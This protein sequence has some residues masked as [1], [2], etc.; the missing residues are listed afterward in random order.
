M[1]GDYEDI[2][3]RS[4][5]GEGEEVG[6]GF[7]F[8]SGDD[9]GWQGGYVEDLGAGRSRGEESACRVLPGACEGNGGG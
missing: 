4:G 7:V 9:A 5:P 6:V 8:V 1:F 3:G 2:L